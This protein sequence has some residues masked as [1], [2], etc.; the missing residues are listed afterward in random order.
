M[1]VDAWQACCIS[2]YQLNDPSHQQ[3]RPFFSSA[4]VV[5]Y[6]RQNAV[7]E[8]SRQL[9]KFKDCQ[10]S[11][12]IVMAFGY[13]QDQFK[14]ALEDPRLSSAGHKHVRI[15]HRHLGKLDISFRRT[16]RVPDNGSTYQLPPDCGPFSIFSVKDY[17]KQLPDLMVTKGGMFIP[18]YKRE[19][20]WINFK[21]RRPF[22]IKIYVGGINA[23]SGEPAVETSGTLQRRKQR[24]NQGK[25]IQ[26]YVVPPNQLWLDGI[27]TADGKVMQFTATPAG[28][29]YSVEAQLSGKSIQLEVSLGTTVSGL[30]EL[31]QDKEGIPPDQQRLIFKESQLEDGKALGYYVIKEGAIIH[32]VL[33][34]RGGGS[35]PYDPEYVKAKEELAASIEKFQVERD[36][37]TKMSE[38]AI[39]PGGLIHQ[40]IDNTIFFNVQ[41]LYPSTFEQLLGFPAPPTPITPE[42]YQ[43]HGYPFFKLYEEKSGIS[44][45]FNG[46]KSVGQMRKGKGKGDEAGLPFRTVEIKRSG[47]GSAF[48]TVSELEAAVGNV[49]I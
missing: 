7:E 11:I 6:L 35:G 14:V 1:H 16:I 26:D 45:D 18:M 39:A 28:S 44:G 33:R 34:L 23:V 4:H 8:R 3:A 32:L 15:S 49:N 30:K 20:M 38:M 37:E 47:Q 17:E 43:K 41:L 9:H 42:V 10:T 31:I 36:L 12:T 27:A 19:A 5:S 48:T 46:I 13:Q 40:T 25:S 22:A 29:G 2:S 21:G 24:L